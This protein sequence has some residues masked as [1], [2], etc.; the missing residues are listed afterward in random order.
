MFPISPDQVKSGVR[1]GILASG[2]VSKEHGGCVT[3]SHT[4]AETWWICHY[5]SHT[6]RGH[7]D[8]V[9]I[10]S[11]QIKINVIQ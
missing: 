10:S 5:V 4:L 7:G 3:V 2:P 8:Y 1:A 11:K 9:T 6:S